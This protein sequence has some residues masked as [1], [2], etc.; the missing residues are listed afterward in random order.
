[1]I[2]Y[3]CQCRY[4]VI[5][6]NYICWAL[7]FNFNGNQYMFDRWG[8]RGRCPPL[9]IHRPDPALDPGQ[10][11]VELGEEG[12]EEVHELPAPMQRASP[13]T[14]SCSASLSV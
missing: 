10:E 7:Y 9:T 12:T 14:G 3:F 11:Q 8:Q 13:A 1:M 6:S 5:L 4:F 2:L